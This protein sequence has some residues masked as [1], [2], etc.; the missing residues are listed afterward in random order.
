MWI[1]KSKTAQIS[2][3]FRVE[4]KAEVRLPN[5]QTAEALLQRRCYPFLQAT[6]SADLDLELEKKPKTYGWEAPAQN[7][8]KEK[9]RERLRER[10]FQWFWFDGTTHS[11][12]SKAADNVSVSLNEPPDVDKSGTQQV[13]NRKPELVNDWKRQFLQQGP[14]EE[15]TWLYR[16]EPR[17]R[18]HWWREFATLRTTAPVTKA[19]GGSRSSSSAQLSCFNDF[20]SWH[21]PADGPT[22]TGERLRLQLEQIGSLRAPGMARVD[23][24]QERLN[25]LKEMLRRAGQTVDASANQLARA[26]QE[27]EETK[28]GPR[29]SPDAER[30]RKSRHERAKRTLTMFVDQLP[31]KIAE[32]HRKVHHL[33]AP[34]LG[35]AT[36]WFRCVESGASKMIKLHRWSQPLLPLWSSKVL[37]RVEPHLKLLT[38]SYQL[39]GYTRAWEVIECFRKFV[40]TGLFI[41]LPSWMQMPGLTRTQSQIFWATIVS[42][43]FGALYAGVGPYDRVL[44]SWLSQL[45]HFDIFVTLL[46]ALILVK[47]QPSAHVIVASSRDKGIE[48]MLLGLLILALAANLTLLL[49]SLH[50]LRKSS[51][52]Q[53][54]EDIEQVEARADGGEE[55]TETKAEYTL[56]LSPQTQRFVSSLFYTSR[57]KRFYNLREEDL[58]DLTIRYML[59]PC[60]ELRAHLQEHLHGINE[61]ELRPIFKAQQLQQSGFELPSVDNLSCQRALNHFAICILRHLDT[62]A[63]GSMAGRRLLSLRVR[64]VVLSE[65]QLHTCAWEE[66]AL[67]FDCLSCDDLGQVRRALKG[68]PKTLLK[69]LGQ[70]AGTARKRSLMKWLQ[71]K[72]WV[73]Y[74][75]GARLRR[76]WS[77]GP[78]ACPQLVWDKNLSW[79]HLHWSDLECMLKTVSNSELQKVVGAHSQ[80]LLELQEIDDAHQTYRRAFAACYGCRGANIYF[81]SV[82][83]AKLMWR[84]MR[85]RLSDLWCKQS[86]PPEIDFINRFL[87]ASSRGTQH[88]LALSLGRCRIEFVLQHDSHRVQ[89][90]RDSKDPSSGTSL[91][92][93]NARMVLEGLEQFPAAQL[94]NDVFFSQL[95]TQLINVYVLPALALENDPA[96]ESLLLPA[97]DTTLGLKW[98]AVGT[99]KPTDGT[100]LTHRKHLADALKTK[101]EFTEVVWRGF[102]VSGLTTKHFIMSAGKYF[103]TLDTISFTTLL[104]LC[105]RLREREDD[106]PSLITLLDE[107]GIPKKAKSLD[108]FLMC[109]REKHEADLASQGLPWVSIVA[110]FRSL[111]SIEKIEGALREERLCRSEHFAHDAGPAWRELKVAQLHGLLENTSK[112]SSGSRGCRSILKSYQISWDILRPAVDDSVLALLDGHGTGLPCSSGQLQDSEQPEKLIRRLV[113]RLLEDRLQGALYHKAHTLHYDTMRRCLRGFEREETERLVRALFDP[114]EFLDQVL[115]AT[116]SHRDAVKI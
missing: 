98:E 27:F 92:W 86:T 60:D 65:L 3:A 114:E 4:V 5:R 94:A 50:H 35:E 83:L 10:Q 67:L 72:A 42:M 105:V 85:S 112:H 45:Y 87:S 89:P 107:L 76:P 15:R 100:E 53:G 96:M 73:L 33:K 63:L 79:L 30:N 101:S 109:V 82:S 113:E 80:A 26:V 12:P 111:G 49:Y 69:L 18:V 25:R 44:L 46:M 54:Q 90:I 9:L 43:L 1:H 20:E 78:L 66:V 28:C 34:Y 39:H 24:E 21:V 32:V 97:L 31:P 40:F 102:G 116:P 93:S 8:A 104:R 19:P 22:E 68:S 62:E 115:A 52:G 75:G 95:R 2:H 11:M 70:M 71:A 6:I 7:L 74:G 38:S 59:M 47:S 64:R 56:K 84:H 16:P 55:H 51:R 13:N 58:A 81:A 17:Q 36:L 88:N 23:A 110:A 106:A 108:L 48:W 99:E 61:D 91:T 14:P 29:E 37:H 57:S 103:K 77:P 41:I